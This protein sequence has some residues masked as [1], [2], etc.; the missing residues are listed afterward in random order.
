MRFA[1]R[2]AGPQTT[3]ATAGGIVSADSYSII[4]QGVDESC[5]FLSC[6]MV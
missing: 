6:L 3:A 2:L 4:S 1:P 5:S